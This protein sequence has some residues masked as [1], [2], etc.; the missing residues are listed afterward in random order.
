M[1]LSRTNKPLWQYVIGVIVVWGLALLGM[2]IGDR[3]RFRDFAL[4]CGG[5][6]IGMFAM[7]IAMHKYRWK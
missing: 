5:F 6:F 4:V 1:P 7:Y 3:A 2:W